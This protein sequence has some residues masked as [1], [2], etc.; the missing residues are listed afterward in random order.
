MHGLYEYRGHCQ[1]HI[2]FISCL[3]IVS[4]RRALKTKTSNGANLVVTGSSGGS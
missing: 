3:E 1:R 2:G 4:G